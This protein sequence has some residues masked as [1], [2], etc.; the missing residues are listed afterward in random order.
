MILSEE[1]MNEVGFAILKKFQKAKVALT[2]A[3]IEEMTAE[4]KQKI[5]DKLKD[6]PKDS[7]ESSIKEWFKG[8]IVKPMI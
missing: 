8:N 3:V 2:D 6:F 7:L 1:F 5:T 4:A